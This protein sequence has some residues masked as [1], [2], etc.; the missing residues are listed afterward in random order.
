MGGGG[1]LRNPKNRI[2]A[3]TLVELLV[4]IAIIGVLIALLLPAVQA[5]R[6]AARRMT[7]SSNMRQFGIALHN[8]HSTFECFP[9]IGTDGHGQTGASVTNSMYSVQATLLPYMEATSLHGLIDYSQAPVLGGGMAA[10]AYVYELRNVIV[11]NIAIMSCPSNSIKKAKGAFN[12]CIDDTNEVST[13]VPCETATG[14]Y[15]VCSGDDIFRISAS[16]EFNCER[17]FETNGLFHYHSSKNID[18]IT[19]GTSNTLAMSEACPGNGGTDH[20]GTI[21]DMQKTHSVLKRLV[22][23]NLTLKDSA[24]YTWSDP[25]TLATNNSGTLSYNELRLT[26]WIHGNPYTT[27]GTFLQPNSKVPSCNWMNHGFYGANSY[28]NNG[29]NALLCDGSVHFVNDS[30]DYTAW[31]AAGTVSGGEV[32]SGIAR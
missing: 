26:T 17:K 31:K 25:A 18:S 11:A 21:D 15:V 4:V 8:Y 1:V 19:D 29:V 5:A 32:T 30:I 22:A 6:E 16:T 9:G 27:F 10:N 28:H 20:S 7:C 3:F 23:V 24:S 2:C 13:A 14:C 12:I